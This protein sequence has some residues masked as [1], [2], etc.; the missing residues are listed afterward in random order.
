MG[1]ADFTIFYTAGE[2]L[3]EGRGADLYDDGVQETVQRSFSPIGLQKRGSI[4]PYNHPPFEA[5]VFVPFVRLSYLTAYLVWLAVN[6]GLTFAVLLLL[7]KNF[8]VLGSAPVYLWLLAGLGFFPWFNAL[9]QGQDSIFVLFFYSM[10]F[11]AFRRRNESRAGAWIGLGLCKFHLVLPFVFPLALL[12]RRRFVASFFSVGF[13][14]LLL[15]LAAVGWRG[16]LSYPLYVWAGENNPGYVW[17]SSAGNT[18]NVR[19][20][21]ATFCPQGDPRLRVCLILLFSALILVGVTYAWRKSLLAAAVHTE[22][23]FALSLVATVLLSYHIFVHD[24]TILFLSALI[25]L[26]VSLSSRVMRSWV[27]SMLFGG[28]GILFCTPIYLLLTLR[29]R[30]MQVM[31]GVLLIFF[32]VLLSEFIRIQPRAEGV[33]GV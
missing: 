27:K 31:G 15:G 11:L 28:I 7:R 13:I 9:L 16:S 21:V 18:S 23:V 10:G 29:Y 32:V 5:I 24:L 17:N 33:G 14:L 19:G 22:L 20:L 30:Q 3:H 4:L 6:L 12:R 26:E 2:I 25:V 1:L 8:S